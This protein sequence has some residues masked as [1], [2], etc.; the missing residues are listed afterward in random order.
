MA[1]DHTL[2]HDGHH[3]PE[4]EYQETPGS[5]Y[6]HTDAD[7]WTT[8]KF[9]IWL[10]VAAIV[11][12]IGMG[13]MYAMFQTQATKLDQPRYP[14]ASNRQQPVPPAPRLQQKPANEIYEFR[15][16]ED[17]ELHNFGYIDQKAGTVHIPIEDAMRQ[18]L[19]KGLPSRT[20]E[21]NPNVETPGLL[22]TDSSSGR[23]MERRRQ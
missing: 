21:G 11:V 8:I 16:T 17:A 23:V 15:T 1:H 13:G 3:D 2:H 18:T 19:A 9:G 12:H 22:A 20:I 14:L 4:A 6:E 5:A 7:T 10:A